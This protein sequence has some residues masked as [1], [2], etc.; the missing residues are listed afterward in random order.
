ML[1]SHSHLKVLEVQRRTLPPKLLN[2][3]TEKKSDSF[4]DRFFQH[5]STGTLFFFFF[6]SHSSGDMAWWPEITNCKAPAPSSNCL[7]K[8]KINLKIKSVSRAF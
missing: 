6:L 7:L 8:F 3:V 4:G 1:E 2:E 5:K